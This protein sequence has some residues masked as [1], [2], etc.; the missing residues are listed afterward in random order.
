MTDTSQAR[1]NLHLDRAAFVEAVRFTAASTGFDARLVE[2]DYFCTLVLELLSG[3]DAL[4]FKGGTCLAKVHT[5]F[6]RLSEDL[7]YTM[8]VSV[9]ATRGERRDTVAPVK[10]AFR[11]LA[12]RQPALRVVE[13]LLGANAS[14]QYLGIVAYSSVVADREERIKVEVALREP[15]LVRPPVEA[16]ASILADP[17]TERPLVPAVHLRCITKIEAYAEKLRAA[18]SRRDV[19][20]R[21]FFDIDHAVRTASIDIGNRRLTAMVRE[22]LKVAGNSPIDVSQTRLATLRGQLD[23]DLRPVLRQVDLASFDLDRAFEIVST[24][25]A[26]VAA[27]E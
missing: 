13:Q 23:T 15:L 17:V 6:Y 11:D 19:A 7:D 27:A 26:Q 22:K 21:D 14:T 9:K 20:V 8:P 25:A 4:V 24:L 1:I 3:I 16:A 10:D 12:Q 2:K 5:S 18:M